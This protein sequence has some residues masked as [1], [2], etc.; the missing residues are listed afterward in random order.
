MP[1]LIQYLSE[2]LSKDLEVGGF[3]TSDE[4]V[5]AIELL[6]KRM[7]PQIEERERM[8]EERRK[9]AI[10]AYDRVVEKMQVMQ[11]NKNWHAAFKTLSY[12][13]GQYEQDLTKELMISLSSE[14]VRTGI[15]AQANMQELG[16]WLHKGVSIAMDQHSRQGI[17]DA[18]DL[19][20]AYGEFFLSEDSGKGTM[21]LGNVLAALEEPAARYE[22]WEE[23][24]TLVGQLYPET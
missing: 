3:I 18:L 10:K 14:A 19:V 13:A 4:A 16:H 20:D 2:G 23:Y 7:Q 12:F 24:K 9:F 11:L 6:S 8:L 15:K 17:E 5:E 21:L 1:H 22:L